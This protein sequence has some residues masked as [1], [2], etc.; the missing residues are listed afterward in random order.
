MEVSA[1][2]AEVRRFERS[3]SSGFALSDAQR[4]LARACGFQSWPKLRAFVD[5][6]DHMVIIT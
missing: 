2:V 3:L 4:V 5:G 6:W 1:A